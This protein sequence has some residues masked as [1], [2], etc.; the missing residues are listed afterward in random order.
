M[1]IGVA[2]DA[3]ENTAQASVATSGVDN[4]S[5]RNHMADKLTDQLVAC[6]SNEAG[7]IWEGNPR[8]LK[9]LKPARI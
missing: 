7:S 5:V 2:I 6:L 8:R 3:S 1:K 4:D 9:Y